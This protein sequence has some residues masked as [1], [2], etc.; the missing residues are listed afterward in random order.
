MSAVLTESFDSAHFGDQRLTK[1]F[2]TIVDRLNSHPNLS[3]P[4]AMRDRAELEAAYR[5]FDNSRVTPSAILEPHVLATYERIRQ[6]KVALLVQD[7]TE[8][9]VTRP[10]VQ[11]DGVGPLSSENRVGLYHH[12]LMGFDS[13]GVPLGTVWSK[14]WVREKIEK[15]L[16]R[17]QKKAALHTT[18]IEEKESLRWLEGVR[19]ARQVANAC[20]DTQC[21]CI[22]DSEADLY[23]VFCE[24]RN[25]SGTNELQL[26]IRACHNRS[27]KD[28]N[29]LLLTAVRATPCLGTSVVEI[30]RRV[31]KVS[32]SKQARKQAREARTAV[33]EIRATTCHLK[34]PPRHDRVLPEV[35]VNVVLVEEQDPPAGEIPIQWILI[36]TLPITTLDEIRL[37]IDYYKTRWEIEVYFKT[38]KAGC[39]V[40]ERYFERI[41][42]LQN[43]FAVYTVV[44]WKV[45]CLTRLSRECPE[46]SCEAVFEPSKWKPVYMTIQR[47]Q[48]PRTPPTLNEMVKMIASLG[49]Y[50]IRKTSQP[51]TQTLWIGLQRLHDLSRAWNSFGPETRC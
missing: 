45:L 8:V 27:L 46:M 47:K 12:P 36:T 15:N 41:G 37:I 5:F 16:T 34:P 49:G 1:R 2:V 48:P 10:E 44:A 22:A 32:V 11:V 7:T 25:T 20:P 33:V 28:R 35:T 39:R 6:S 31:A 18:P 13:Q 38:L 17:L 9:D 43:C 50:V 40:E 24:P 14:T 42:R 23:E 4:A 21:V 26:L 19:V 3:I 51:G 29:E 30:S